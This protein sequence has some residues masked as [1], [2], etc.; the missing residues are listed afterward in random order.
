MSEFSSYAF[1]SYGFAMTLIGDFDEASRFGSLALRL[2]ERFR[3]DARILITVYGLLHHLKNPILDTTGPVLRAYRV[4]LSQGDLIFAGQ[5]SATHCLGMFVAG[6]GLGNIISDLFRFCDQLKTCNQFLL[7]NRLATIQRSLLEL[8]NRSDEMSRLTGTVLDDE[9]FEEYLKRV[10]ADAPVSF[11]YMFTTICRFY[12]GDIESAF[13]FG[14]KAWRSKSLRDASIFAVPCFLFSAL[15]ALD[16]WKRT[17]RMHFRYWRIFRKNHRELKTWARKGN[18]NTSHFVTLLDAELLVVRK[19]NASEVRDTY[20][21]SIAMASRAGLVNDAA[22]AN[23]RV[24]SYFLDIMDSHWASHYLTR[25][26]ELFDAW[27]AS[28]KV[29]QL[30]KTYGN[31]VH[32]DAPSQQQ[33]LAVEGRSRQPSIVLVEEELSSPILPMGPPA[34]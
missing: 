18:P 8:T 25:A 6:L 28:A 7:W 10:K 20:D 2:M 15:T 30:E 14:E 11:F 19:A 9:E 29:H 3:E 12:L 5:A 1:S 4:A 26:L 23:E 31:L 32:D 13:K 21:R 34:A 16:H 22:L 27:G 33:D 24:G 17:G